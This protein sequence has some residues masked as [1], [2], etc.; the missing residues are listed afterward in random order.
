[1]HMLKSLSLSLREY[2]PSPREVGETLGKPV[3]FG[4]G[5]ISRKIPL[6]LGHSWNSGI[7]EPVGATHVITL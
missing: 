6:H 1:M 4:Q 3:C 7:S 5:K 2:D